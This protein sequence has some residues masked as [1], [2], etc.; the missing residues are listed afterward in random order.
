[1]QVNWWLHS[2]E[3]EEE[4]KLGAAWTA[5]GSEWK[6]LLDGK[7]FPFIPSPFTWHHNSLEVKN[8]SKNINVRAWKRWK[9]HRKWM[10]ERLNRIR[11]KY[12]IY[13]RK[14]EKSFTLFRKSE[15]NFPTQFSLY[16]WRGLRKW[17]S[18]LCRVHLTSRF[19]PS[20]SP[21]RS[22]ASSLPSP[23]ENKLYAEGE[24][25]WI[26]FEWEGLISR[27]TRRRIE[28]EIFPTR[29]SLHINSWCIMPSQQ[30]H[31][32]KREATSRDND[33]IKHPC[34]HTAFVRAQRQKHSF[35]SKAQRHIN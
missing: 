28:G 4:G 30:F 14:G 35:P 19:L 25:K 15:N 18:L 22:Y 27:V 26:I 13:I 33:I 1:M 3:Q 12:W 7:S 6:T 10:E 9:F 16:S 2:V 24:S 17:A 11:H 20:I 23:R 34:S 31:W 5:H 8:A 32:S 29:S 21:S